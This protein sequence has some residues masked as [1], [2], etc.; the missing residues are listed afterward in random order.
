VLFSAKKRSKRGNLPGDGRQKD[1]RQTLR[2]RRAGG[3]L[4]HSIHS[5]KKVARMPSKDRRE[6]LKVLKKN[7]RR[8]R[9]ASSVDRSCEVVHQASSEGAQSSAS[10]N[11]DWKHWVVKQG[12]DRMTVDD[13]WGIGK[14]I[15]IKF[16]G[17]NSNMFN[18]LSRASKSKQ[19]RV[20]RRRR[21]ARSIVLQW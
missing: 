3:L 5:L 4:R 21:G 13:V 6:V 8:S 19:V 11:N 7:V 10:V 1:E 14:A 15:G 12:N 18:V 9:G 20:V 17:D 2:K 16:K